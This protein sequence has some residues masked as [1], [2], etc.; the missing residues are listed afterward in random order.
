MLIYFQ[1]GFFETS[2]LVYIPLL[3]I[4][5]FLGSYLGKQLLHRISQ[6]SFKKLVLLLLLAI[7]IAMLVKLNSVS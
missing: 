1:N 2:Y 5:S 4:A 6:E 3:F 7:G